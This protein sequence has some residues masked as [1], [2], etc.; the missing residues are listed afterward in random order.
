MTKNKNPSFKLVIQE[1]WLSIIKS[2]YG[3]SIAKYILNDE[4]LSA[5]LKR[6]R[7]R[8]VCPLLPLVFNLVLVVLEI[9]IRQEKEIKDIQTGRQELK[10]SLFA[11]E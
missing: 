7:T 1:T 4:K 10:L 3:K 5:F 8:Q 11:D 6:S 9:A 2:I